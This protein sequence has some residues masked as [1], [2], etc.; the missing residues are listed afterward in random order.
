MRK[1][2]FQEFLFFKQDNFTKKNPICNRV[3]RFFF[4]IFR[5]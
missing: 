2:L 4:L 3:L 5:G 1:S